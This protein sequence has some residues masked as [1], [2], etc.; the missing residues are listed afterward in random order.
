MGNGAA[1]VLGHFLGDLEAALEF[2]SEMP[3]SHSIEV[4]PRYRFHCHRNT[5]QDYALYIG[6]TAFS[7]WI[8]LV[9]VG[10]DYSTSQYRVQA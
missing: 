6:H 4:V 8:R 10:E 5:Q 9:S 3:S 2:S 7:L 1:S